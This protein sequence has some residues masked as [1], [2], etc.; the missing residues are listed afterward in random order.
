M[1]QGPSRP[2]PSY[3]HDHMGFCLPNEVQIWDPALRYMH[4]GLPRMN[5]NMHPDMAAAAHSRASIGSRLEY[6]TDRCRE[7]GGVSFSNVN[8]NALEMHTAPMQRCGI[9]A[10]AVC[11]SSSLIASASFLAEISVRSPR[12]LFIFI[13]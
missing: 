12:K 13:I 2:L 1:S 4:G 3:Y 10:F 8:V 11:F 5:M 7:N 6:E 9:D